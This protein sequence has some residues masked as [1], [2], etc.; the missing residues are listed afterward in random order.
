MNEVK[1]EEQRQIDEEILGYV[2]EMQQLAP[3]TEDS[4]FKYL[5]KTRRREVTQVAVKDR[6]NYLTSAD[7]LKAEKEWDGKEFIRYTITADGMD[8]MDGLLPPRNWGKK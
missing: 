6:I 5:V 8:R 4:I 1:R 7:F 2:R 3:V